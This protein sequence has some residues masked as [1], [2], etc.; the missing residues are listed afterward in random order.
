MIIAWHCEEGKQAGKW[1]LTLSYSLTQ[2]HRILDL[3]QVL[4][5]T[6]TFPNPHLQILF[7]GE[8]WIFKQ[9][10]Y[11]FCCQHAIIHFTIKNHAETCKLIHGPLLLIIQ[12]ERPQAIRM[13]YNNPNS[14]II[15]V[16]FFLF[17]PEL[18]LCFINVEEGARYFFHK[19]NGFRGIWGF[20]PSPLKRC[21]CGWKHIK[22][23][24]TSSLKNFNL[25]LM[26]ILIPSM[27]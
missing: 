2:Y 12:T 9:Y 22:W 20:S 24:C 17:V 7:Q 21:Q 8:M 10:L 15:L 18:A 5:F 1:C 16:L 3:I 11:L 25:S 27:R 4:G 19:D 26:M 13:S 23:R 6:N 14:L